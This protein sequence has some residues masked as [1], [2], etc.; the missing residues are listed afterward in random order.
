MEISLESYNTL[1]K[2]IKKT[3]G[4]SQENIVKTINHQKVVMSWNIG[5]IIDDH[6]KKNSGTG[7]GEKLFLQLEEDTAIKVRTL[8]QMRGFFKAYPEL[9]K[10]D[11]NLSWSHYRNLVTVKDPQK[12]QDFE[13][14]AIENNLGADKLQQEI[15]KENAKKTKPAKANK[16]TTLKQ[17]TYQ[18]GSLFH[19]KIKTLNHPQKGNFIDCGFNIFFPTKNPLPGSNGD[20]IE[21]VKI[22][23]NFIF[24]TSTTPT[25]Q[26]HTYKAYLDRVVDGDT[27]T[28]MLDLGFGIQ[29]KEIIRLAKI[30]APESKTIEGQ[31]S[32]T[33]LKELLKDVPFLILKT[34]K[35]DIYG[36]YIADIFFDKNELDAQKVADEGAY[37]NQLLLDQQLATIF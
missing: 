4:E 10:A 25:N 17:L 11:T 29:H 35:T 32:T 2:K 13:F 21:S 9:P 16:T 5:Q 20:V 15:R 31:K 26:L 30:N 34:N 37:L 19:Y 23:D 18:R 6:L 22:G 1:L 36:R 14:F 28:V 7:Y 24:K 33:A 3:L 27:I 12:R 8:Y